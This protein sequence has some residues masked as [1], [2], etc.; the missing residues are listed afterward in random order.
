MARLTQDQWAEMRREWEASP[1]QGL[2]WLTVAGGGR[3]DITE[4]PIRKRRAA[5]GWQKPV[6]MAAVMR[7][8]HA[9][10]DAQSAAGLMMTGPVPQSRSMPHDVGSLPPKSAAPSSADDAGADAAP[11]DA[12]RDAPRDAIPPGATSPGAEAIAVDLR[13]EL[14]ERHRK[15]WGAVRRMFYRSIQIAEGAVGFDA[16]K[17]AKISAETAE[18][19][20]RGEARAWGLDSLTIDFEGMSETQLE[21]IVKHG[22]LP[23]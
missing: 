23:K 11:R 4:E 20:Q 15:E 19:I 5:E 21:A 9:A 2:T 17:F 1:T 10:A 14:L 13:T 16:A 8:A 7:R 12:G 3:W 18:L 6:D 22:R